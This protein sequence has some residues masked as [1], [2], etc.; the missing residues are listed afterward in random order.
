M[1]DDV[2]R[3]PVIGFDLV[4]DAIGGWRVLEDNARVPSGVGYAVAM[5]RLMHEVMPELV[6]ARAH[7][8]RRGRPRP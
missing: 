4:R 6:A 1:P 5:R 8:E 2:V 7:A 3:A